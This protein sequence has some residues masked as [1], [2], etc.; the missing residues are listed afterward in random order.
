MAWR[1][2]HL[3]ITKQHPRMIRP[4]TESSHQNSPKPER[5]DTLP[6]GILV[7]RSIWEEIQSIIVASVYFRF[8]VDFLLRGSLSQIS[9][10]RNLLKVCGNIMGQ[11]LH[12]KQSMRHG[13]R[14]T[15]IYKDFANSEL[16]VLHF[17]LAP[18]TRCSNH[19]RA[20]NI[21]SQYRQGLLGYYLLSQSTHS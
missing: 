2:R 5:T 6:T 10:W 14:R 16:V 18:N 7:I 21:S 15:F 20:V 4:L 3:R 8:R 17:M 11:E 19:T 12:P 9:V 1:K 13:S